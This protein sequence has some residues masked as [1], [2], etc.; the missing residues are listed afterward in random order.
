M[1]LQGRIMKVLPVQTGTSKQGNQWKK[2]DFILEYVH[3][4]YPKQL[5]LSTLDENVCGKLAVGQEVEA[6]VDFTV[7]EWTS[8]QGVVKYFNEP[9]L[10]RDGLHLVNAQSPSV[11]SGPTFQ[12][13]TVQQTAQAPSPAPQQGSNNLPF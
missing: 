8:P 10:W 2:Q 3:G 7:R 11:Q 9:R 12:P 6:N 1:K 5:Y 13:P 4:E